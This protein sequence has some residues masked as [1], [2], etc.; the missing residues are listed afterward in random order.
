[1]NTADYIALEKRHATNTYNPLDVVIARGEGVWVWDVEGKK[2]LDCLSAYSALNQGHRHPRIVNA[3]IEQTQRV[4]LTSRAFYND[5]FPLLA[6]ELCALTGYPMML[7]MNSG[8]EAVEAALKAARLWGYR[9]KGVPD[10]QAEIIVCAHNF[11]G[12]T[13]TAISLSTTP[14]YRQGFGPLTPGFKAIPYGD[15]A[16]LEAAITPHT[17]GFLVE[18]IQGEGG[19]IVPPEGFLRAARQVCDR[20]NV[21]FIADE[22]QTG[23][24]RTGQLFACDWEGVRPDMIV[25]GKALSG[26]MLPISAVVGRQEILGLF[27]PGMHGSTFGGNPLSAAVAREALKVIVEEK[28]PERAR[29]LGARALRELRAIDSPF[30]AGVR[31]KGLLI[32]IVLKDEVGNARRFCRQLKERGLLMLETHDTVIRFA[33]PLIITEDVLAWA[34]GEIRATFTDTQHSP[35]VG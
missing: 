32:G 24:G 26:G 18:P 34:L 23:L 17:V 28:L 2:Y 8:A 16:A 15:A 1:M 6:Q 21:L 20:H 35:A 33:P 22:I 25:M 4:T 13:I 10:N 3:L 31:G 9:V 7:P 27:S 29:E 5:Q 19:V 14:L 11:H 12:R 30:I